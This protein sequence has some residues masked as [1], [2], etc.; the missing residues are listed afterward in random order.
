MN[1]TLRQTITFRQE[2]HPLYPKFHQCATTW[3]PVLEKANSWL[4]MIMMYFVPLCMIFFSYG[5]I[6]ISITR[7]ISEP[8]KIPLCS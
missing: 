3:Y 7:N 6:L 5:A 2:T 8:R 4:S 1:L